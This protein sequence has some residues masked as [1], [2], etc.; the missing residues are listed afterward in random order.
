MYGCNCVSV[1]LPLPALPSPFIVVVIVVLGVR[2]EMVYAS[3]FSGDAYLFP[4]SAFPKAS[5]F[6]S[7]NSCPPC[8]HVRFDIIQIPLL[9]YSP[10]D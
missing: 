10:S 6:V 4:Y 3:R 5:P 7:S 8:T 2:L 9:M 1:F